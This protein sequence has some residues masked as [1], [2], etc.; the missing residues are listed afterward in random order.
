MHKIFA[1][2]FFCLNLFFS[3]SQ[4]NITIQGDFH[5]IYEKGDGFLYFIQINP[6]S[7]FL[8]NHGDILY[9]GLPVEKKEIIGKLNKIC[10][11]DSYVFLDEKNDEEIIMFYIEKGVDKEFYQKLIFN[12]IYWEYRSLFSELEYKEKQKDLKNKNEKRL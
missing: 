5:I 4:N 7:P 9:S 12:F 2:L 6:S 3:F 10:G 8:P 1:T 11:V